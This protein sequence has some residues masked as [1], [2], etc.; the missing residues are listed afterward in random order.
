M[1]FDTLCRSFTILQKSFWYLITCFSDKPS[2]VK[3]SRCSLIPRNIVPPSVF[4]KEEYVSHILTG[5][6]FAASLHSYSWFS[7]SSNWFNISCFTMSASNQL[8]SPYIFTNKSAHKTI[9]VIQIINLQYDIILPH[10]K[11]WIND[12]S[13][14]ARDKHYPLSRRMGFSISLL[15]PYSSAFK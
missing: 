5:R 4:A 13:P 7:F 12:K 9:L 3:E 10:N 6:P 1:F 11:M 8:L 14:S 2:T 15:F